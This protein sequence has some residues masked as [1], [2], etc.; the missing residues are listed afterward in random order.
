MGTQ[1]PQ[2]I[3]GFP[4]YMPNEQ[5]LFNSW[6]DIIR[7]TYQLYGFVPIETPAVERRSTL[8]AK[9]GVEHEIYGLTRL[10]DVS[11]DEDTD[12]ALHFDLTVPLARYVAMN[13]G[14][15]AFP[16]KRYQMQKVWRG[17]RAQKGRFREFYQCDIDV[18]GK[19][20]LS[21]LADA[22]M[23]SI[24]YRIFTQMKIGRFMIRVSNRKITQAFFAQ[25]GV[26]PHHMKAAREI[27][28]GLEKLGLIHTTQALQ[29][30]VGIT[31]TQARA[32]IDELSVTR[33]NDEMM[34]YLS[35]L[36]EDDGMKH[37]I[38]ELRT[39]IDHMRTL[40][41]PD[42]AFRIDPLVMRGLDYYTGTVYETLLL[43][44]PGLGSVCSGGRYDD[45]AGFFTSSHLP[46]VGVSIGL[47]RLFSEL[48]GAFLTEDPASTIAP[49]LVIAGSD[50]DLPVALH[51]AE[52]CRKVG[53]AVE[54]SLQTVDISKQMRYAVRRKF[55]LVVIVGGEHGV[56]DHVR[57]RDLRVG[58]THSYPPLEVPSN[59]QYLLTLTK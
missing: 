19:N 2:S 42:H 26:A 41:V 31:E 35:A 11:G 50:E 8:T 40:G 34:A 48:K 55:S 53:I 3:S 36:P 44:Y 23:P 7:K 13:E 51:I 1:T 43:D 58:V 24:I 39:V 49:V 25:R 9:G 6:L 33:S 32:L 17:E 16:F 29:K 22:E 56:V 57:V 46:G 30:Q 52:E 38:A 59:V 4:E 28:D 12:L 27:V 21:L 37:G 54:S 14:R 10:R 20:S 5:I 18:I 15:L 45:L 47:T